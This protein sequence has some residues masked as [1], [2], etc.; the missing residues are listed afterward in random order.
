MARGGL[1]EARISYRAGGGQDT[2]LLTTEGPWAILRLMSIPDAK[3]TASGTALS[4]EWH[5]LQA[6]RRTPLTLS[7]TGKAIVVHLDFDAG[8][9]AFVFQSGNFSGLACKT[10][11]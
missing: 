6:D 10:G 2:D 3:V 1:Q 8:S 5:P 7:G 4:A 11:R 9:S